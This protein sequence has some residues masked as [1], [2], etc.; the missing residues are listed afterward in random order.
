VFKNSYTYRGRRF[1]VKRWSVK[2]QHGRIRRTFSLGAKNRTA[3]AIEAQ[4]IYQTIVTQGWDAVSPPERGRGGS[5]PPDSE[6]ES[7]S[8]PKTD[9]R[10]WKRRL[11]LRRHPSPTNP[12]LNAGL[13]A[14][15][16]HA[17]LNHYFPLGTP[18]EEAAAAQARE[19]YLAVVQEGWEAVGQRFP[20]ELTVGIQWAENPLAWTYTSVHTLVEGPFPKARS[21]STK[22]G[23]QFNVAIL[24]P[25]AGVRRALARCVNVQ[26]GFAC[27]T[28]F[29][30]SY[31]VLGDLPRST[32][33]LALVNA[34]SPQVVAAVFSLLSY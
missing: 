33:D 31:E 22:L 25:D 26:P 23:Q 24:E 11:L 15:I 30:S 5:L 19:I 32:P 2:I 34:G 28:A 3:A 7:E 4:A 10:Y 9:L 16:E 1:T 13:S 12:S 8:L 6:A 20:R 14:R 18:D 21:D 29:S 17:G 27:T